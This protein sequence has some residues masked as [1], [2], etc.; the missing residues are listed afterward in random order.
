M[1]FYFSCTGN[2][3]WVAEQIA[4]GT[5]DKLT[6]IDELIKKGENPSDIIINDDRI[7]IVFPTHCWRAPKPVVD[8]VKRLSVPKGVFRY[9]VATCGD[10]MGK[11]MR[12]FSKAFHPD[13]AWTVQ[14]PNTYI[15]MFNLDTDEVAQKKIDD[16]HARIAEIVDAVCQ[17]WSTWSIKEGGFPRF[18]SYA[19]YPSFVK[20]YKHTE[21]F[22]LS[23]NCV[24]CGKC[25]E[26]CPMENVKIE[27][28]KPSWSN[29]C[30][31]C[32]ACVHICPQKVIQYGKG[33]EKRGRYSLLKYLK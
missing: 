5:N 23:G 16:A 21:R 25:A 10:N 19:I 32:M 18:K 2:S 1:I 11:G 9:A 31:Q 14:M 30:I 27:G 7:G 3:R 15:P 12:L 6:N 29:H 13:S 8:F 33:T 22:H 20:G 26:A 4:L 24:E 28:G 17:C